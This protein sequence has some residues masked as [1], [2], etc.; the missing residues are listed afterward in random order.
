MLYPSKAICFFG[1]IKA[2]AFNQALSGWV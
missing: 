1:D 2:L